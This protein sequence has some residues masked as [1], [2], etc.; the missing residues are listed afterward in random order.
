MTFI[1]ANFIVNLIFLLLLLSL[2]FFAEFIFPIKNKMLFF[3]YDCIG[4]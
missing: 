4:N 3:N 1:I 2:I